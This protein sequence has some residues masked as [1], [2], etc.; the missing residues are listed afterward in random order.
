MS[1]LTDKH[2]NWIDYAKGIGIF[3]MVVGHSGLPDYVQKMI[4]SFH[5]PLFF[6]ISGVLFNHAKYSTIVAL[7]NRIWKSLIIP[8]LFFST[9]VIFGYV[10]INIINGKDILC[11]WGGVTLLTWGWGGIAL[12]FV[13]TLCITQVL[14]WI[15][16]FYKT[17]A[18]TRNLIIVMSTLFILVMSYCA[19]NYE[20]KLPYKLE[21]VGLSL[22]FYSTGFLTKKYVI[23]KSSSILLS[24][25][26]LLFTV[27]GSQFF[28]RFDICSNNF[29]SGIPSLILA[30]SGTLGTIIFAKNIES[31]N[32]LYIVKN[33]VKWGGKNTFTIMGLSQ[34][35]MLIL[36]EVFKLFPLP[37]SISSLLRI[38]LMWSILKASTY[39]FNKYLPVCVGK[40]KQ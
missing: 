16:S 39:I 14:F 4:W 6:F 19:H 11:D 34:I 33:I 18:H 1:E 24:I 25:T 35:I 21:N 30:F 9:I 32:R 37:S 8:Y 28:D 26:L 29:S 20:V 22:L 36:I 15:V 40:N 27:I 3:L 5:M 31:I 7:L 10:A 23:E 17:N 2:Y 13:S 38:V 12:W